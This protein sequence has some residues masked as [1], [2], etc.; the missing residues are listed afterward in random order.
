MA[1]ATKKLLKNSGFRKYDFLDLPTDCDLFLMD[2]K[3]LPEWEAEWIKVF[4]G[5]DG[6]PYEVG[7]VSFASVKHSSQDRAE[8]EWFANTHTRFHS[9]ITAIPKEAFVIC[10]EA[11]EYER[12]S[13]I[14][15]K[16]DWLASLHSRTHSTFAMIDVSDFTAALNSGSVTSDALHVLRDEIDRLA[17]ASPLVSFTSF[18]DSLLLKTNWAI[19][20]WDNPTSMN[21]EPETFIAL[22]S[23][24]NDAYR[25]ILNAETYAVIA[26]GSNEYYGAELV[27][28]SS[29]GNHI[30]LNSLGLPFAQLAAIE[31]AARSGFKNGLHPRSELYLDRDFFLSLGINDHE[32][33][34]CLPRFKYKTKLAF[35]EVSYVCA[36]RADILS[37]LK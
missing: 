12:K 7:Y 23:D 4:E 1:A 29:R 26:Q 22:I 30:S 33:R 3:W 14:F 10:A 35:R 28:T 19:G 5:A 13:T 2:V 6:S 27:H 24:I 21:Y 32:W 11:Y 36:S 8:I 20:S 18:A 25:A 37:R 16:G 15:V 9:I 34:S 31:S 17:D